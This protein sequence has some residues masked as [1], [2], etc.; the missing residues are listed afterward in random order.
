MDNGQG[1]E[2][3]KSDHE[4]LCDGANMGYREKG[5]VFAVGRVEVVFQQISLDDEPLPV[6]VYF[7]EVNNVFRV[8]VAV[9]LN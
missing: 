2:A 3:I 6:I 1:V 7:F 9:C 8:R 5:G 4:L